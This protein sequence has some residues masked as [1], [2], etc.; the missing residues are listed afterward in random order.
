MYAAVVN[1]APISAPSQNRFAHVGGGYGAPCVG[2]GCSFFE[3]KSPRIELN[4]D[5]QGL[6]LKFVNHLVAFGQELDGILLMGLV[7]TNNA[8]KGEI[9]EFKLGKDSSLDERDGRHLILGGRIGHGVGRSGRGEEPEGDAE[10]RK[11]EEGARFHKG[12]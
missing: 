12:S 7:R 2:G 3:G 5:L 9:G 10:S 6:V 11:R 8:G 4:P 1:A